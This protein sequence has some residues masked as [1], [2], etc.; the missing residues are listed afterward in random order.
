MKALSDKIMLYSA[1]EDKVEV[2]VSLRMSLRDAQR[3][4]ETL[5]EVLAR[6]KPLSVEI[7]PQKQRRTLD[8]N[9]LMWSILGQMAAALQ[10]T[11]D[12]LYL[13]ML[14]RYGV[15]T[16]LIVKPEA[17]ARVKQEWRTVRELGEV[18]VNGKTGIQ[19]QVF[20]GSS[21]YDRKEF[22]VL[23]DG[24]ISEAKDI[25][26]DIVSEQEKDLLLSEWGKK[27]D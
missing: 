17:V 6:G 2:V 22:S 10:T 20:F 16:H 15:F 13:E 19:L 12:E 3:G 8:A 11:K 23:L 26:I 18:T 25:G 24:V 21:T 5:N 9:S 1:S 14:D 4:V 27:S 7:M